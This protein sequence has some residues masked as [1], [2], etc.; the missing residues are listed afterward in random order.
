MSKRHDDSVP[1]G[2]LRR[3][4]RLVKMAPQAGLAWIGA[5]DSDRMAQVVTDTLGKLK[6]GSMKVGQVLAQVADDLPP[7]LRLQLGALYGEVP[8]LPID[9]VHA[10]LQAEIG[11]VERFA[12]FSDT[13]LAAASL[14]QVHAA[15]LTDGTEVA[16]K[17]QYPGVEQALR[18]D[19]DLLRR[20]QRA[21]TGGGLLFDPSAYFEKL[22][23]L[24]L[25][26]LDYRREADQ[27]DVL[28]AAVARWPELV[29]PEVHRELSSGRVLTLDR[30]EGPMLHDWAAGEHDAVARDRLG[31]IL[32]RAILG[33]VAHAHVANSDAHPGNF[34][35][36][37]D[38]RLGLLD[39][40]AVATVSGERVDALFALT[41]LLRSADDGPALVVALRAAGFVVALSDRRAERI[42]RALAEALGPFLRGPHDFSADTPMKR[43]MK[44]KMDF[45]LES[46]ALRPSAEILPVMR[47]SVGLAHGLRLLR[48]RVDLEQAL[49]G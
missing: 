21:V 46:V 23:D 37:P 45:P 44:L 32:V 26:E 30:L 41:P 8:A 24:T 18:D 40:G 42:A 35:V 48:A 6:G 1:T 16:V 28:A 39:F 36:L 22:R 19:L 5:A 13:P 49:S 14:G 31:A 2:R 4:G 33:P 11:G 47:A 29:V 9:E 12:W 43:I 3:L 34:V 20:T 15:R 38:G 10:V 17:V 7:Q 27:R 25:G